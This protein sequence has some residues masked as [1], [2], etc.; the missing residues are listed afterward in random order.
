MCKSER[1]RRSLCGVRG[2]SRLVKSCV[3]MGAGMGCEWPGCGLVQT[4]VSVVCVCVC[5]CVS[6][7]VCV[8]VCLCVSVSVCLSVC[9]SVCVFVCVSVCVSGCVWPGCGLV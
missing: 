3:E 9:L 1:S 5:V 7:S 8:C 4:V 6:V 2:G